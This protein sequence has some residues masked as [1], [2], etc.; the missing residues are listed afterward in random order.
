MM[1]LEKLKK[2]ELTSSIPALIL[3]LVLGIGLIL[4]SG[5]FKLV[6]G[7]EPL[8]KL[9]PS[10]IEGEYVSY[11]LWLSFDYFAEMLST[12]DAGEVSQ[13]LDY[14]VPVE[15]EYYLAVRIYPADYEKMMKFTE[16]SFAWL[17][18]ETDELP[19]PY[20]IQGVVC[21]IESDEL[22]YY[23]DYIGLYGTEAEAQGYLPLV[24]DTHAMRDDGMDMVTASVIALLGGACLV[25]A[26]WSVHAALTMRHHKEI[27]EYLNKHP[28]KEAELDNWME[29]TPD[30]NGIKMDSQW[31]SHVTK[32]QT[33]FEL[34]ENILWVYQHVTQHRVYFFI[35]A[36]KSHSLVIGTRSGKFWT[37]PMRSEQRVKETMEYMVGANPKIVRGYSKELEQLFSK[38]RETFSHLMEQKN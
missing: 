17:D 29:N 27:V 13:F 34:S 24:I 25:W 18:Y 1:F 5:I 8:E 10:S 19:E 12:T 15:E 20:H 14:L 32:T 33:K 36:G 23:Y 35:P 11:D 4:Y 22:N 7:P 37:I 30:V 9:D 21:P 28:E 3:K 16:D 6:E 26:V 31:C 38:D 2:K